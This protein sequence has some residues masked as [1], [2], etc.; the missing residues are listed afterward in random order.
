M[1]AL[2]LKTPVAKEFIDKVFDV[3]AAQNK[4]HPR[5]LEGFELSETPLRRPAHAEFEAELDQTPTAAA[6]SSSLTPKNLNKMGLE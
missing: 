3:W 6:A 2:A 1:V 4:F 5:N